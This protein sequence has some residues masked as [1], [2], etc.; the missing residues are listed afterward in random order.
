MEK[1][2]RIPFEYLNGKTTMYGLECL[3]GKTTI[4]TA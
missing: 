2:Q 4:Y 3:H 1:Q